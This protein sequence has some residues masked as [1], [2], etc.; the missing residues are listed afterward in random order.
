MLC[1]YNQ[2]H[3]DVD[4][5]VNSAIRSCIG[6]LSTL[7]GDLSV[8]RCTCQLNFLEKASVMSEAIESP[9]VVGSSGFVWIIGIITMTV[10]INSHK[11]PMLIIH[12]DWN[13]QFFN[14]NV[15]TVCQNILSF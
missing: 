13:K 11:N 15:P 9:N 12:I 8:I 4:T 3:T 6:R 7:I 2:G 14:E 5:T 1:V 10:H